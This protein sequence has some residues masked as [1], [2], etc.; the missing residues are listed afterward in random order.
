[1]RRLGRPRHGR[2]VVTRIGGGDPSSVAVSLLIGDDSWCCY[3]DA[4]FCFSSSLFSEIARRRFILFPVA[5]GTRKLPCGN[6]IKFLLIQGICL[7]IRSD[8]PECLSW[9]LPWR[10]LPYCPCDVCHARLTLLCEC[11]SC[12][13]QLRGK[14]ERG[15]Y[16][17]L[18]LNN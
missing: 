12:T 3:S 2:S 17:S 9:A 5:C 18:P 7:R 1:M 4:V 15:M 11:R 6:R 10:L 13:R 14:V 8:M 16:D